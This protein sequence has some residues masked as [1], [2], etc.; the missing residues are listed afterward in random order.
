M[1]AEMTGRMGNG[2]AKFIE[3]EVRGT[4]GTYGRFSL[5]GSGLSLSLS[6]LLLLLHDSLTM[7]LV[8][9]SFILYHHVV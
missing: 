5:S 7:L 9:S 3:S 1:I 6:L 2:M 4:I 8:T